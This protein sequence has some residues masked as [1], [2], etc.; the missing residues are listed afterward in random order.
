MC[1]IRI[2]AKNMGDPYYEPT[3]MVHDTNFATY[4]STRNYHPFNLLSL[5]A[6]K[7]S[8]QSTFFPATISLWN[9]LPNLAKD[10]NSLEVFKSIIKI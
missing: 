7:T 6:S 3:T 9:D 1:S 2:F 4:S 8:Y 10:S 5:Q